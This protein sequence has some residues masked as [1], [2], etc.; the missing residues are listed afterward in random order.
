M[1]TAGL[2]PIGLHV[3]VWNEPLLLSVLLPEYG[4]QGVAVN[5]LWPKTV[6]D[7]AALAMLGGMVKAENCHPPGSWL[8]HLSFA[9]D[10]RHAS[11]RFLLMEEV[12]HE[13]GITDF[14]SYA[15]AAG[16]PLCSDL[17]LD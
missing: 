4:E 17:F 8:M 5:A 14:N 10:C 2:N 11:G 15:V 6:I 7:T 3:Q 12:L 16:Q 13:E 1:T 9:R